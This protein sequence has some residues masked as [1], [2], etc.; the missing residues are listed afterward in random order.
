MEY[1]VSDIRV[2]KQH[3]MT[4]PNKDTNK[5]KSL[6]IKKD[7]NKKSIQNDNKI[8]LQIL[9]AMTIEINNCYKIPFNPGFIIL[10]IYNK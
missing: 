9:E 7:N 2:I 4:K 6:D 10:K 8:S 3:P 1:Y 5:L